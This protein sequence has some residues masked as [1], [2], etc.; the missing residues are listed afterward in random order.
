MGLIIQ[1]YP[2]AGANYQHHPDHRNNQGGKSQWIISE[3][4]ER[5]SFGNAVAQGWIVG[6]VG[7]GVHPPNT[8]PQV[9]GVSQDR[10]RQLYIAKFVASQAPV[11]WHGYPADHQRHPQDVPA[12]PILRNWLTGAL[13]V[14]AKIRKLLKGQ[15]CTL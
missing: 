4:S 15:P 11:L 13:F 12:A 1:Q 6:R 14:P 9:L 3:E 2:V 7:W 5:A 10:R 8:Q